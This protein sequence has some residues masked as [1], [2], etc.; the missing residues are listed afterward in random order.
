MGKR[1]L[2]VA[3]GAGDINLTILP[4]RGKDYCVISIE[5][6]AVSISGRKIVDTDHSQRSLL[7]LLSKMPSAEAV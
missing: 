4:R 6:M 5:M 7:L 3:G 2:G 1:T